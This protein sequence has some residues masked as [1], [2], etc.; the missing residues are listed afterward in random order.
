[1]EG[2]GFREKTKSDFQTD[3]KEA[4][5][6]AEE[7]GVIR[8]EVFA[9]ASA[10]FDDFAGGENDL[11]AE[12]VVGGHAV[13]QTMCA[14]G[15]EGD[16]A[17]DGA[18]RLAG[19]IG[20]EVKSVRRG[21]FGDVEIDHSRLDDSDA[22]IGIELDDFCE[23]VE[24]DD[25]PFGDRKRASGKAGARAA[26]DEGDFVFVAPADDGDNL[27]L[28]FR[29][30]DGAG[31]GAEGGEPVG[32]VSGEVN[33]FHEETIRGKD[34]LEF[35]DGLLEGVFQDAG[36]L[37][38]F[39]EGGENEIDVSLRRGMTHDADAP[40]FAG[41]GAK[42]CA[43]FNAVVVEQSG[44]DGGIVGVFRFV[45]AVEIVKGMRGDVVQ[46]ERF[47]TGAEAKV[48]CAMTFDAIFESFFEDE[49]KGFAESVGHV[50]GRS[51]VIGTAAIG[52]SHVVITQHRDV[53]IPALDFR[54]AG[55]H[56]F[57]GAV[58]EG[59]GRESRRAGEVFLGAGING[60]D[61]PVV[62]FEFVAAERGDGIDEEKHV[63]VVNEL[64]NS[65]ERLVGTG[66]SFRVND[67]EELGLGMRSDGF[68]SGFVGND[69]APGCFDGVNSGSATLHDVL[70]ASTEDA[71]EADDGLVAGFEEID[72]ESFH[73][74][75]AG[76]GDGE[77]HLVFRLINLAK[78]LAGFVHDLDILRIE[79]AQSGRAHRG[80][81]A[82]RD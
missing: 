47:E 65:F 1:M 68:G 48:I 20:R 16:V 32:L 70:H 78:H 36:R 67:G 37:E 31:F 21:G 10:E 50:D 41:H 12:D 15:I 76:A 81:N 62:D 82:G 54:L 39:L 46:S 61:S 79:V 9:T 44:A 51:V 26:G 71:V 22:V 34:R 49:E 23:A 38:R 60:V 66:R 30:D 77:S 6:S 52:I 59:D 45:H 2:L 73:A 13:F 8:A 53:E 7:S 63:G 58:G 56:D 80:E 33:V 72:R 42:A 57:E 75:H 18:D 24:G 28:I 27:I 11:H 4:F 29:N 14:A 17:S 69:F 43:D 3:A 55:F 74:S 40:G 25:D 35:G 19:R 64:G 5:G